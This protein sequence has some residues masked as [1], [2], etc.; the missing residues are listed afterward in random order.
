[1]YTCYFNILLY[2]AEST[3]N[4]SVFL[5]VTTDANFLCGS[6]VGL[7]FYDTITV[8]C[9]KPFFGRYVKINGTLVTGTEIAVDGIGDIHKSSPF[10]LCEVEVYAKLTDDVLSYEGIP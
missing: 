10:E 5:G 1:M 2:F 9:T 3:K 7:G 4:I 6:H 8:T